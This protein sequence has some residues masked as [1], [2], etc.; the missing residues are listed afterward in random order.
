MNKLVIG[1]G[2]IESLDDD[3][4]RVTIHIKFFGTQDLFTGALRL[5]QLQKLILLAVKKRNFGLLPAL[6]KKVVE[7]LGLML[8]AS[9]NLVE[10]GSRMEGIHLSFADQ[11]MA[12]YE[13]CCRFCDAKDGDVIIWE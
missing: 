10:A 12:I 8:D 5:T 4:A 1:K 13:V 6:K 7:Q 2:A 9:G 3:I 11:S